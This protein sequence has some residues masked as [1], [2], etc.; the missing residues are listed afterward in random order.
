MDYALETRHDLSLHY[1]KMAIHST[2]NKILIN[3]ILSYR[4]HNLI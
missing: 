4:L 3:D 2:N 1:A